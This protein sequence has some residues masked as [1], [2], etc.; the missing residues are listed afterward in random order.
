VFHGLSTWHLVPQWYSRKS[1][2]DAGELRSNYRDG[3][4]HQ[5]L[6]QVLRDH[7][8]HHILAQTE[9]A[10]IACS[11]TAAEADIVLD[12]IAPGLAVPLAPEA[13]EDTLASALGA[14]VAC[15][16]ECVAQ[17]GVTAEKLQ[18]VYLTG[19]SS[20]LAPLGE[21]LARVFPQATLTVGD[22]FTSVAAGLA[23]GGAALG[24]GAEIL[25]EIAA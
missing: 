22:R 8:G 23:Y 10:K 19:G 5:R 18:A 20:A 24:A 11:D 12:C 9:A 14:I 7:Q 16:Q 21:A 3:Q 13:L 1:L 17:A 4:M 15:A 2:H 25:D 6:M